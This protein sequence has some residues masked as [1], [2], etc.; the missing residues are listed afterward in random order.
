MVQEK[1]PPKRVF[2]SVFR[3]FL[4]LGVVL[5]LLLVLDV[6]LLAFPQPLLR[7]RVEVGTVVIHYPGDPAPEIQ[8][9]ARQSAHRLQVGG[10]GDPASPRRIFFFPGQGLYS[11]FARLARVPP[12]AQGFGISLLG[13]TYVSGVRVE[14]L[15]QRT[16]HAPRY[17]VWEG[18]LSHTMAHEVA[19]L[20]MIDSIGRSSW[21]ALPQWKQEGYPEY[22]ANIGLIRQDPTAGLSHRIEILLDDARW[23][24]PRSWDRI[25]YEAGLMVEF[26]LDVQG[27]DLRSLI[28]DQ[29]TRDDTYSAMMEWYETGSGS[30]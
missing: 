6:G 11:L 12:E 24:G 30:P 18:D 27:A 9:L 26:L 16:G 23:P 29:V 7:N 19:H 25:H 5:I 8:E 17:S 3:L 4:W 15:G 14:A 28:S 13:N 22:I 10:F 21:T 20:F 1:S 2:K